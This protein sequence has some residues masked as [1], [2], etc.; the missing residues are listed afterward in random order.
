MSFRW[1]DAD[2]RNQCL[3]SFVRN[4][5]NGRKI[6]CIFNFSAQY[7]GCSINVEDDGQYYEL[8]N[9]DRDKYSG[10]NCL[11]EHCTANG[12]KLNISLAPLSAVMLRKKD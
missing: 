10:S 1:L 9:S 5:L 11:N 6:Y 3:Y 2:N 7:Q 4:D 12:Y 8:I